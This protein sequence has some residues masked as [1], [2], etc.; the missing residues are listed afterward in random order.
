[1][2]CC[3]CHDHKYDPLSQREYYQLFA[4][5]NSDVERD[6]PAPL[7]GSDEEHARRKAEHEKKSAELRRPV[8]EA[9]AAW[10]AG[11][12]D[13]ERAALPAAVKAA[14]AVP[15]E[16]R[17]AKQ[18]QTVSDALAKADAKFAALAKALAEHQKK[19]PKPLLA[20]TLALGPA[21]KTHVMVR[22]DFLRPGAEVQPGVP[23]V[24]PPLKADGPPTRLD[25]A[26]WL[27]AA[28]NPLTARVAANW[29]WHKYFGRGLVATPEDF[30][31]Q[32]QRPA[33][34]ELLDH[35]AT[36]LMARKWSLKAFHRYVV[37]SATYRQWS[38]TRPE[39]AQRDPN[40]VLLAR[41]ARL[42]L[43]AELLRDAALA[44]SGLLTRT[45][46]G[47]SVRP[48]QPPGISE[49][50]YASS[51]K[52][53]ES[54][55]PDRYRRGLYVWFQ[56]TSPYPMLLTFDAPDGNVCVVRRERT[57]TP[58]QALTLLNDAVFI[59]CA[60]ALGRRVLAE[61]PGTTAERARHA[62]RLCVGRA[63]TEKELA[64]LVRLYE[65][66]YALAKARP[67][68]AAKLAGKG[69]KGDVA[70]AAAWAAVGRA[71]LNLDEF[72]TRE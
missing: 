18:Q 21:R 50:T 57:T 65:E 45:V 6:L 29:V 47:P 27:V 55:G 44:A 32:G 19:A 59:E 53:V 72:Q 49:L 15:A 56:R 67:E 33:H 7:P 58:L 46:G 43:E 60:Q 30:G 54:A 48:P 41:Q 35:L 42:R 40:N 1:M 66:L 22:G 4:F 51:A 37:T 10:E 61:A 20:Q 2:G 5:F 11:L 24:L 36:E 16:K 8:A 71:L 31:T 14:L 23:A 69:V 63:P 9:L 70:E 68:E 25:L 3:Q 13:K 39:L 17:D 38:A 28:D 12:T 62:F 34:P 64:R 26:R 52:W